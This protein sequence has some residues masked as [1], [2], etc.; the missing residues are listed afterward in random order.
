MAMITAEA[1]G[2]ALSKR[3]VQFNNL[4][5]IPAIPKTVQKIAE[6]TCVHV[7]N[8]GPWTWTQEMGLGVF[9]IPGC[10]E[11]QEF[12]R[13]TPI[14]GIVYEY[15]IKDETEYILRAEA[16]DETTGGSTGGRYVA[17]QVIGIGKM[18]MPS[19]DLR[20]YGV[21]IGEKIGPDAQPTK[22]EIAKAKNALAATADNYINEADNAYRTSPKALE[23]TLTDK[24]HWA[25]R[26]RNLDYREHLWMRR[27]AGSVA[28]RQACPM[29]GTTS[30]AGIVLC[31]TC[32]YIFDEEKYKTLKARVAA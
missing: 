28:Q 19:E 6:D 3:N 20:P 7:Y 22:M 11:G 4:R 12:S 1:I 23:E 32:R 21:F 17:E 8:V 15:I 27:D 10:P 18:R 24:H 25:A 16:G 31:P 13:M 9:R 14:P 26:F 5:R 29:C 30:E 2:E